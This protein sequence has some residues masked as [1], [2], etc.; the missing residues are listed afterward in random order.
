MRNVAI[1]ENMTE[2][3]LRMFRIA[4]MGASILTTTNLW[5]DPW[6]RTNTLTKAYLGNLLKNMYIYQLD[7]NIAYHHFFFET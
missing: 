6:F 2:N 1:L 3:S 4:M 5:S 7:Q